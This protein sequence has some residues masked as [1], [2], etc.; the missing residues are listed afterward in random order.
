MTPVT[1][2][3]SGVLVVDGRKAFPICVSNPPPLGRRAPNGKDGWQE[4]A[5]GGVSFV[6]TGRGDW[7]A[8]EIDA[9]IAAEQALEDAAAVHGLRCWLW[10]GKLPNLPPA[11]AGQPPSPNEQLLQRSW[12]RSRHTRGSGP[13]KASTSR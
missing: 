13:T 3:G 8:Q 5:A 4:L 11:S 9:Q 7:N 10:L 12:P 6:R 2:D 1:I